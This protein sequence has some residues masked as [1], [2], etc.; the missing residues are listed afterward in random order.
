MTDFLFAMFRLSVDSPDHWKV[1]D[2]HYEFDL[3]VPGPAEEVIRLPAL[4]G[5]LSVECNQ[6]LGCLFLMKLGLCNYNE[7][8]WL[9]WWS[10]R[11]YSAIMH[12]HIA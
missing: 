7:G 3:T 6:S 11:L 12:R 4:G 9:C 1:A 8:G 5:L 10:L 2:C